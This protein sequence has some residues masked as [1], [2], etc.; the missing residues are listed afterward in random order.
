[1]KRISCCLL[2][3][4]S[5]LNSSIIFAQNDS[6]VATLTVSGSGK[7]QDEAKQ[8]ALRNAIE[9][10]FGT[11]I[12]SNTQILNDQ[13]LKDEIVSISNGNIQEY[14]VISEVQTPDG[15]WSN[16]VKAKVAIDKLTSFC[17][18]KGVN[19][20]FKGKLFAL[21]IK[22]QELNEKNE[23]TAI[24]N[25][26][27]VLKK[28]I[29]NCFDYEISAGNPVQSND[30][31]NKW[32]IPLTVIIKPNNNL[33][34][35][36]DYFVNTLK[37][38][39]IND[40]EVNNYKQLGKKIYNIELMVNSDIKNDIPNNTE[41][42]DKKNKRKKTTTNSDFGTPIESS[43]SKVSLNI[44]L[45]NEKSRYYISDFLA[46]FAKGLLNF[47]IISEDTFIWGGQFCKEGNFVGKS[48]NFD[49]IDNGFKPRFES[50]YSTD[51]HS[52]LY[53]F[54]NYVFNDKNGIDYRFMGVIPI[55][56]A[57]LPID[58]KVVM[59]RF[60]DKKTTAEI[61]KITGYKISPFKNRLILEILGGNHRMIT[62]KK[63]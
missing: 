14:T 21:N 12:T 33:K 30:G 17:E 23:E 29:E 7:S 45:R 22:Q 31:S 19:S 50:K 51:T 28:L 39:A 63:E 38:I 34:I 58:K 10:A 61:S 4:L 52:I 18:S 62:N 1:M 11:F 49:I 6:K 46:Y 2:I 24:E 32:D 5:V 59:I 15:S 44:W 9:Q 41:I 48:I 53:P 40:I 43:K 8:N 36:S 60:T 16:T 54:K 35:I 13:L 47:K 37:G 3:I 42:E 56:F 25:M 20:E 26:C 57:D 27:N 55:T